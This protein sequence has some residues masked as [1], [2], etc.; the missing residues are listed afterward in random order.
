MSEAGVNFESGRG[1]GFD[2]FLRLALEVALSVFLTLPAIVLRR[3]LLVAVEN[4]LRALYTDADEEVTSLLLSRVGVILRLECKLRLNTLTRI[5]A[6]SLSPSRVEVLTRSTDPLGT[7]MLRS[8]T[9]TLISGENDSIKHYASREINLLTVANFLDCPALQII[10]AAFL[11]YIQPS[12]SD[13][14]NYVRLRLFNL[15]SY[16]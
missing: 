4:V 8:S 6:V 5:L 11:A 3:T 9:G 10:K 7:G 16:M 15:D 14:C 13:P 2:T 12:L 1:S